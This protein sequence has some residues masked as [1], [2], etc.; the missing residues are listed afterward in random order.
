MPFVNHHEHNVLS[1]ETKVKT[2]QKEGVGAGFLCLISAFIK[3]TLQIYR[4]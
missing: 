3:Q 4:L 2:L 1:G